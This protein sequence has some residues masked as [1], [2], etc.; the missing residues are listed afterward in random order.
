M[1][2][3]NTSKIKNTVTYS[4]DKDS[5]KKPKDTITDIK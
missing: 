4:V 1:L 2:E 3:I 5:M